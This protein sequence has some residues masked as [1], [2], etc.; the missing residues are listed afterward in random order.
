MLNLTQKERLLLEDQKSHEEICVQK[1]HSFANQ[2]QD[3]QLQQ[4]LR[5]YGTQE[6]QHL[7][8]INQI[9]AGQVPPLPQQSQAGGRAMPS[10]GGANPGPGAVIYRAK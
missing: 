2:V 4:L 6:Q 7:Q 9:L 3:P 1:Y 5:D 8:T 10:T